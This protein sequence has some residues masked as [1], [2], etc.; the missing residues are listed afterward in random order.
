MESDFRF[1]GTPKGETP[2]VSPSPLTL[3]GELSE[4]Q[5][6]ELMG[7]EELRKRFVLLTQ[8]E[9]IAFMALLCGKGLHEAA[10]LA[11]LPFGRM[12]KNLA[13]KIPDL[14]ELRGL[15]DDVLI[16]KLEHLMNATEV[17]VF[18]DKDAGIV[19][20]DPLEALDINLR[21]LDLIIKLKGWKRSSDDDE[22][23]TNG[24]REIT[25]NNFFSGAQ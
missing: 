11:Q 12:K 2:T 13:N 4:G 17:K 18:N 5:V 22:P 6:Y 7:Q 9:R 21:A 23:E 16:A 20:S 10:K 15:T 19:Y 24:K 14:M 25:V 3:L 1:N 8:K